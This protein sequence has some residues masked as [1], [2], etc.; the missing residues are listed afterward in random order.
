M[1]QNKTYTN[2]LN[3]TVLL[4]MLMKIK[5]KEKQ[6]KTINKKGG[7]SKQNWLNDCDN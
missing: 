5:R 6:Q 2:K 4:N 3:I 7:K 1:P